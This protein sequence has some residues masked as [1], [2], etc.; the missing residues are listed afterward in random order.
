MLLKRVIATL[1]I[2]FYP[3]AKADTVYLHSVT[4]EECKEPGCI[5]FYPEASARIA[6]AIVDLQ[7]CLYEVKRYKEF[8]PVV[9]NKSWYEDPTYVV[10]GVAVSFFLGGLLVY[11][12]TRR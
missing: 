2:L 1:L 6:G 4:P 9:V 10:G 7:N 8:A 3:V 5:C 11:S 12:L